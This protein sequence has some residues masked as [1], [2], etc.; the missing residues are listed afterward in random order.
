MRI[1]S[2]LLNVELLGGRASE[3]F[4]ISSKFPEDRERRLLPEVSIS[5][6]SKSSIFGREVGH[7]WDAVPP[8]LCPLALFKKRRL[9]TD[10]IL[11]RARNLG[12]IDIVFKG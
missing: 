1:F 12:W 10:D 6:S 3:R 5:A 11:V 9:P 8:S 4:Q 7:F 2:Y